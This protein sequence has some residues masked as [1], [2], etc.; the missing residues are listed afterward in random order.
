[1]KKKNIWIIIG[2]ILLIIG[3][4]VFLNIRQK[5]LDARPFNVY[6]Y[7]ASINVINGTK[8]EKA[9]TIILSLA[10]QI[11]KLD[12]VDIM[13]YYIPNHLNSGDIEFYGIVQQLPYD[14]R[15]FLI[16]VNRNL[17]L[18]KLFETLSH[19]FIHIDQYSRGDLEIFEHYAIWKG[20]TLDML[21]VKYDDRLFEKEAF[22]NQ[23]MVARELKK[24]LYDE[25]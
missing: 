11:F 21:E 17:N 25:G 7:P 6:E 16:L 12:T 10:H 23:D 9:D 2:V 18:T 3:L 5:K 8:F 13:V 19:E 20:D 15:K 22:R 1:M 14:D 24:L 4:I